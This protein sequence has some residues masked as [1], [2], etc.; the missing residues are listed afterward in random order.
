MFEIRLS[1]DGSK[2]RPYLDGAADFKTE[3]RRRMTEVYPP[4][5]GRKTAKSWQNLH[6]NYV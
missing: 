3:D 4:L 1:L 2:N 6:P 5:A